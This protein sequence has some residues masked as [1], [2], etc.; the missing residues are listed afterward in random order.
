MSASVSNAANAT[1]TLTIALT[2]TIVSTGI[3]AP[4]GP[5]KR[6]A[7]I[8]AGW[9]RAARVEAGYGQSDVAM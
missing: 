9:T 6:A 1:N 2:T 8:H 4:L 5:R 7:A 3:T